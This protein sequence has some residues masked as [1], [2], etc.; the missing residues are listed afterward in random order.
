V[1]DA[2]ARK[3]G[4]SDQSGSGAAWSQSVDDLARAGPATPTETRRQ[5][6]GS[7]HVLAHQRASRLKPAKPA[8]DQATGAGSGRADQ[9][10]FP[11]TSGIPGAESPTATRS[12]G[13]PARADPRGGYSAPGLIPGQDHA[14][15]KRLGLH[16]V[17][18]HP[19]V[20][21]REERRAAAHQD[22]CA[23]QPCLRSRPVIGNINTHSS[24]R[25]AWNRPLASTSLSS[26]A[27]TTSRSYTNA[28]A[29]RS[30]TDLGALLSERKGRLVVAGTPID[31]CI[32]STLHGMLVSGYDAMLVEDAHTT[33]DIR[34]RGA[35]LAP[36][37]PSPTPICTGAGRTRPAARVER[38]QQPKPT[39]LRR[40]SRIDRTLHGPSARKPRGE[41]PRA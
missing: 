41:G 22:R 17:Q 27:K 6:A 5:R 2:L 23:D 28:T 38:P 3:A 36:T 14:V 18:V 30:N 1:A 16:Q 9:A 39:S 25:P 7:A 12:L 20:Q 11:R 37:N 26:L 24:T 4:E 35:P 33:E 8:T 10:V 29:T 31:A 40:E 34:E 32:R 15:G 21:R 19:V 13:G